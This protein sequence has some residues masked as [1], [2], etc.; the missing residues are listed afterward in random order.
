MT[1]SLT[2]ERKSQRKQFCDLLTLLKKLTLKSQIMTLKLC[3][4]NGSVSLALFSTFRIFFFLRTLCIVNMST[5]GAK[6]DFENTPRG[7]RLICILA[8]WSHPLGIAGHWP[9]K[10]KYCYFVKSTQPSGPCCLWK[11]LYMTFKMFPWKGA[12][13]YLNI[14]FSCLLVGTLE[15]VLFE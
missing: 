9:S 13:A 15:S 3:L 4:H 5:R 14:F 10:T 2:L 8:P 12:K 6:W 7:T 11:C 1:P